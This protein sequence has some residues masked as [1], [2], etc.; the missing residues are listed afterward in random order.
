[1]WLGGHRDLARFN[2]SPAGITGGDRFGGGGLYGGSMRSL[3][4]LDT[5][6]LGIFNNR[7]NGGRRGLQLGHVNSLLFGLVVGI[8]G[9][10]GHFQVM[11]FLAQLLKAVDG[12]GPLL[13]VSSFPGVH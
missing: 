9:H 5:V 6:M 2:A 7:G 4:S 3:I 13:A 12:G 10:T 8:I 11:F 1:M